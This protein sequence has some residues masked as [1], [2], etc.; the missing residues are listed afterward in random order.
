MVKLKFTIMIV[1]LTLLISYFLGAQSRLWKLPDCD[2]FNCGKVIGRIIDSE[3]KQNIK[4]RF[5]IAFCDCYITDKSKIFEG[6]YITYLIDSDSKGNFE[7]NIPVG[8]YCL[9]FYPIETDS[10]YCADPTPSLNPQYTQMIDV[11]RGKI[12]TIEKLAKPGGHLKI[13]LVD[14]NNNNSINPIKLFGENVDIH[15]KLSSERVSPA[16]EWGG[17]QTDKLGLNDGET[18]LNLPPEKYQ[19]NV[20][21]WQMG[22]GSQ[23]FGN[24]EIERNKT[25]EIR[26]ILD[27]NDRT[28]I[29]GKVT[30]QN[31][32]PL[33][34]I[35]VA[36]KSIKD[37]DLFFFSDFGDI[38]TDIKGIYKI[39][40]LK[41]Q[42]YNI[43]IYGKINGKEIE[44]TIEGIE[45]KSNVI[46]IKNIIIN[47]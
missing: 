34:N 38:Y 18:I 41:E 35:H 28:G 33:E 9:Q 31:G 11:K 13:V 26:I 30:D 46:R 6:E 23:R 19:L 17:S 20:E 47:I 45:I 16:I 43:Y 3:T 15:V 10:K 37:K 14:I 2:Y 1:I 25:K 5:Y 32:K 44:K 22:Y 12:A 40:G 39:V 29:E 27:L 21:F 24:I 8:K 4:E 42:I 36:V 7:V